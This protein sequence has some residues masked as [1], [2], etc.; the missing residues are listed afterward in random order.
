MNQKN[1]KCHTGPRIA[2]GVGADPAS[3]GKI[4]IFMN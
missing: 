1:L 2:S 3:E 4:H